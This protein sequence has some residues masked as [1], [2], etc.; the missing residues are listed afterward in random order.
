MKKIL[1]LIILLAVSS[2]AFA[3]LSD[4]LLLANARNNLTNAGF[5]LSVYDEAS[6]LF[7]EGVQQKIEPNVPLLGVKFGGNLSRLVSDSVTETS[8]KSGIRGG[9]MYGVYYS[10]IFTLETGIM[11]EGKGFVKNNTEITE[12]TVDTAFIRLMEKYD[13]SARFHYIQVPLYGRFTFGDNVRFYATAGLSLGIPIMTQQEGTRQYKT[14]IQM[15]SGVNTSLEAEPDTLTGGTEEFQGLDLSGAI[16]VGFEWPLNFKGF[17]GPAP[18]LFVDVKY[19]RSLMSIGQA[20]SREVSVAGDMVELDLPAT[21]T[22][23]EGVA[24]TAGLIFP[25]SVR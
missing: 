4:E 15:N 5:T 11:Y 21:E 17:T 6:P 25:L 14:F 2:S 7:V 22:F 18:S 9:F 1:S 23:N 16:G 13:L 10:K 8:G 20:T 19:H 3:Q 24:I 12:Y